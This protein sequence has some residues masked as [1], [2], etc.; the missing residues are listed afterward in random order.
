M[1]H[2]RAIGQEGGQRVV[3][4]AV[5]LRM[6]TEL[7]GAVSQLMVSDRAEGAD[8]AL[9][10]LLHTAGGSSASGGEYD[11]LEPALALRG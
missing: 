2:S 4:I 11:L 5:Q 10:T 7:S 1:Q 8:A 3:E 6:C 9:S